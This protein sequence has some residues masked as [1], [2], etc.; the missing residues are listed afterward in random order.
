MADPW[1]N[2]SVDKNKGNKTQVHPPSSPSTLDQKLSKHPYP[3]TIK[4]INPSGR[5]SHNTTET[6]INSS[7]KEPD[8]SLEKKQ[9]QIKTNPPPQRPHTHS[10]P[11]GK[12][13]PRHWQERRP[14]GQ[15]R[16]EYCV[17]LDQSL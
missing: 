15:I 5:Y 11:N 17:P 3:T 9:A 14:Q 4:S 1:T 2:H 16:P 6:C 8:P 13:R 12:N 7:G 10:R